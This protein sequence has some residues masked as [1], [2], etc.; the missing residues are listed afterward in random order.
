MTSFVLKL[1]TIVSFSG[2]KC[3]E[4]CKSTFYDMRAVTPHF[5]QYEPADL[6]IFP[7]LSHALTLDGCLKIVYVLKSLYPNLLAC[8][9]YF[10]M[11]PAYEFSIACSIPSSMLLSFEYER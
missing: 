3:Q 9:L 4:H 6:N 1:R 8:W 7:K 2:Q 11:F 5:I 10:E